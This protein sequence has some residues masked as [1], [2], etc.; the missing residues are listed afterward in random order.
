MSIFQLL[1]IAAAAYCICS[2]LVYFTR[3]VR[4]GKPKDLSEKSGDVNKGI[5]Y[6]N[7][8][9]MMPQ[10]KESAYLHFP[11]YATGMLFHI[12]TFSCFLI[13][14][15]SFFPFFNEWLQSGTC[16]HLIIPAIL[17]ITCI[18]GYIL[19]FK[20]IFSKSLKGWSNPD[21]YIS[22][23]VTSTFQLM[24][25]LYLVMPTCSAIVSLYYIICA[26]LFVYLPLGK[27]RHVVFYFAA[28]YHLGFFYGW[29]NVWPKRENQ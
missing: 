16:I 2:L 8:V 12:G 9:A 17:A 5:L 11:S 18:S 10:N 13:W 28:R 6:S 20:R 19:L 25:I 4:L 1:A 29:R 15:L 3:I 21:D 23:A 27:L 14:I 22:N 24:T 7:T 26:I